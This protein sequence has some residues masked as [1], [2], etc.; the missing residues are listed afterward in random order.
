[1]PEQNTASDARRRERWIVCFAAV[2]IVAARSFVFVFRP[3]SY[4]DSDQAVFG[5]MAKHLAE[6]RAFPLFMYGQS[7][8][9]G[10]E[11]WLAAPLFA[12]FGPSATLLKLPLLAM[13]AVIVVLLLRIFEREAGLRPIA[14]FAAALPVVLPAVATA[15]VFVEPSGGNVEPYLYSILIWLTRTSP[16]VCGAIFGVGFLQR[17]FTV[18]ALAALVVVELM[19]RRF[20]TRDALVRWTKLLGASAVVWILVQALRLVSSGSGPGTSLDHLYGGSNN[21]AEL[22]NRTCVS[23]GGTF[24]AAGRLFTVHWPELLG[25]APYPLAGFAIES[26]G[27]QGFDGASW[28]LAAIA[29]IP[30]AAVAGHLVAR[31]GPVP[32]CAVYFTMV[33]VFSVCGYLFGRCGEVSVWGLR[34]ELLSPL[35]LAGLA[36]WFLAVHPPRA[37]ILAWS[38][39]VAAWM[40]VIVVPHV[41]LAAEYAR[42][43]P[44]PAKQELIRVLRAKRVR[45]ATADYWLAYYVTFM[46]NERIIVAANEVQ[47]IYSY[48]DI[49]REHA[50]ETIHLSRRACGGGEELIRGVYRCP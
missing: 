33:G 38:A 29:G 41:R 25:T 7:Y 16:A 19:Q 3:E 8:I 20:L 47:R 22:L 45:Y 37:A 50:A 6:L 21:I 35:G 18:Y 36:C 27:T 11:A 23:F 2:T 1:M 13:N 24:G 12:L 15:A 34:Y 26:A 49:I 40:A 48:N 44:T 28:L 46:T 43:P 31:R 30:V 5:L 42:N 9:L 17:Q 32:C 39:A 14:A 4:F 10:V